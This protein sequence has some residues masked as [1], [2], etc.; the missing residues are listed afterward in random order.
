MTLHEFS[1]IST[2]ILGGF[3]II[4]GTFGIFRF[5][6][7]F[8]RGHALAKSFTMGISLI[9][10]SCWLYLET[11]NAGLKIFVAILFQFSTIPL[12]SHVMGLVAL[13][14]NTPRW[15]AETIDHFRKTS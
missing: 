6:D 15:R 13:R 9:L 14:K 3:F 11:G 10:I 7:F 8:T 12:S 1:I 4:L 2:L 5:P